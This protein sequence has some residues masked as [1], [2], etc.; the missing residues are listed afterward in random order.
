M[1][2]ILMTNI[3]IFYPKSIG[4]NIDNLHYSDRQRHFARVR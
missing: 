3:V 2:N 1:N 4:K